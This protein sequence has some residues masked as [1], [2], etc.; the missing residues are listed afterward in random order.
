MP[1]RAPYYENLPGQLDM[2]KDYA[3]P[4]CNSDRMVDARPYVALLAADDWRPMSEYV[5]SAEYVYVK[6]YAYMAP[7]PSVAVAR[8]G[9]HE[10]SYWFSPPPDGL[11]SLGVTAWKPIPEDGISI[12]DRMDWLYGN[13]E[14][15]AFVRPPELV[16]EPGGVDVRLTPVP[17]DLLVAMHA[18]ARLRERAWRWTEWSLQKPGKDPDRIRQRGVESL[19]KVAFIERDGVLPPGRLPRWLEFDWQVTKHGLAW[20]A[21]NLR[22]CVTKGGL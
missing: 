1:D 19:R 16:Y 9:K 22:F 10:F 11:V 7:G 20:L 8:R 6:G 12:Y 13:P 14:S 2:W 15:G 4:A 17:R 21:Q 3:T 18:G 5:P